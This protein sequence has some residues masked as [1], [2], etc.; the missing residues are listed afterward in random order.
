MEHLGCQ[1]ADEIDVVRDEDERARVLGQR[2]DEGVDG[3]D[4]EVG[5]RLVH[6]EQV[7]RVEQEL[8]QREAGFFTAAQDLDLLEDVVAVEKEAT[9]ER[10][11]EEFR[12]ACLGVEGLGE[13]RPLHLEHL[14]PV[15][16]IVAR[17]DAEAEVAFTGGRCERA[18]EEL[19]ERGL[20]GAVG[21][22]EHEAFPFD[23]LEVEILVDGA[24]AIG[25]VHLLERD[26]AVAGRFGLGEIEVDGGGGGL[27]GADL[28]HPF[29][30]LE[31]GLGAGRGGVLGAELVHEVHQA[32]DLALLVL[33]GGEL[34]LLLGLALLE[35]AVVVPLVPPHAAVPEFEDSGD[36]LV[37][38]LAIVGDDHDSARV[39]AEIALEPDQRLEVEVVRRFVQHQ[40]VGLLNEQ[41][42]EV[43]AHHPAAG[44]FA[45]GPVKVRF[46]EREA[47]EDALGLRHGLS[48]HVAVRLGAGGDL[49]DGFLAGRSGLLRQ[50]PDG[51]SPLPGHEAFIGRFL[52]EEDL[53][54]GGLAR[55]VWTHEAQTI[56]AV[57][58]EADALEEVAS[59]IA[60]GDFGESKHSAPRKF[61]SGDS[62]GSCVCF[63]AG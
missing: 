51:R 37:Q 31:L 12:D 50:E 63:Q 32:I 40:E 29:D 60:L 59:A 22:D 44:E 11:D 47:L 38:E 39:I 13:D 18:G 16:G 19:E 52:I 1:G 33:E 4:V 49:E 41:T 28:F 15:L 43:G 21:A 54:E 46:L 30:L 48:V 57:D 5:G 36:H 27:G 9:E 7:R 42:G 26:D 6:E 14:G 24:F 20:A 17:V 8:H 23:C 53:E 45:G 10:P 61:A 56:V 35:E 25:E 2:S 3:G 58:G 34:L 62:L 55:T